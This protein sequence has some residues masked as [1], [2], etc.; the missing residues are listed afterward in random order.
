M[1]SYHYSLEKMHKTRQSEFVKKWA[2]GV[3]VA[4]ILA[5]VY[6]FA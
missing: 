2:I 6:V 4:M 5:V 3:Y 1:I